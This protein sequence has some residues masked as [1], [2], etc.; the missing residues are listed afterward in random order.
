MQIPFFNILTIVLGME[1]GERNE[2]NGTWSFL[3]SLAEGF[4]W[5]PKIVLA[6]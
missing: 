2:S 1:R 4:Q 6:E 3:Q 5:I